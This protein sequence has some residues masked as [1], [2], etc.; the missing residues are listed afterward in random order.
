[1]TQIPFNVLLI[2][3][4]CSD[5]TLVTEAM[6][7]SPLNNTLCHVSSIEHAIRH[8]KNEDQAAIFTPINAIIVSMNLGEE[9]IAHFLKSAPPVGDAGHIP[10]ILLTTISRNKSARTYGRIGITD[11]V[12]KS[13]SFEHFV[14]ALTVTLRKYADPTA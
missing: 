12:M 14:G 2:E 7:A 6:K 8:L 10:T 3:N 5:T 1:V 4:L 13:L 11:F 9:E